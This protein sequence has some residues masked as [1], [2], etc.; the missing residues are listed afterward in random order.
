MG[1]D[2]ATEGALCQNLAVLGCQTIEEHLGDSARIILE[3]LTQ[4]LE[5]GAGSMPAVL[6]DRLR[7]SPLL[8]DE[9]LQSDFKSLHR[10]RGILN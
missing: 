3:V 2:E 10:I 1:R 5:V 6:L 9:C 8:S 7:S 4:F